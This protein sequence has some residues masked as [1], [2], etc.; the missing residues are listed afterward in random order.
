M[1]RMNRP[2]FGRFFITFAACSFCVAIGIPQF[3]VA[4]DKHPFT[5]EDSSVLHRAA[6]EV[7]VPAEVAGV[8]LCSN[9]YLGLADHPL[10]KQRMADAV[11]ARPDV[12]SLLVDGRAYEIKREQ[13]ATDLHLWVGSQPFAVELR[14]PRSLRSRRDSPGDV[15]GPKKLVCPMP[16]KIVRVMVEEHAEVEAGQ[17]IVVVEAMKMQNEL[18][19]NRTGR[20]LSVPAKEGATV[21]AG[22]LLATS[23]PL[24]ASGSLVS[25][26]EGMT[27]TATAN[28]PKIRKRPLA[29]LMVSSH[30]QTN[31]ARHPP[32][33]LHRHTFSRCCH[34]LTDYGQGTCPRESH[35]TGTKVSNPI[36]C[37]HLGHLSNRNRG[38]P[39]GDGPIRGPTWRPGGGRA[40]M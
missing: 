31:H 28:P 5:W 4:Q 21:T 18:K 24:A 19:S 27:Y 6:P 12:L 30:T 13:T 33:T 39:T 32:C 1:Q 22:E 34:G 10:L 37:S 26:T 35:R 38:R 23:V 16:G 17:G 40:G 29:L 11:M 36:F 25:L 9:D 8:N 14:D 20:V 3:V 15:G 2:T 7:D